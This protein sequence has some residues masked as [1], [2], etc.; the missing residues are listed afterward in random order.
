MRGCPSAL[1]KSGMFCSKLGS[2]LVVEYSNYSEDA[3]VVD[4]G[5]A[6][7]YFGC[8][9]FGLV[10]RQSET[11]CLKRQYISTSGKRDRE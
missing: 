7:C 3:S 5:V 9:D 11:A 4:L 10:I 8:L 2:S 1:A 6:L